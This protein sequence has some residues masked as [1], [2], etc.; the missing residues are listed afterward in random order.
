MKNNVGNTDKWV[1]FAIAIAL[2]VLYFTG[3]VTG[4]LA[5]AALAVGGIMLVTAAIGTCP[6]Y[7][8]LGINTCPVPKKS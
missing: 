1:R 5:Y 2:G 6:I 7:S 3:T 8:L 4:V